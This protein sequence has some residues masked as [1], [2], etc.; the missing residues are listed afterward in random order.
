MTHYAH[1]DSIAVI[2]R[3]SLPWLAYFKDM[4]E[5]LHIWADRRRQRRELLDFLSVDHRAVGDIGVSENE[6]RDWAA[7]PFWYP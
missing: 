2:A 7:R 3:R 5:I 1:R 4:M 6:I